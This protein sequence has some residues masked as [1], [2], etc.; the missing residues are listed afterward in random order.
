MELKL[1]SSAMSEEKQHTQNLKATLTPISKL[2]DE[3]LVVQYNKNLLLYNNSVI[4][5]KEGREGIKE[6]KSIDN[7]Y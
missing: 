6:G 5:L 1:K 2:K 4:N 3:Q 7:D